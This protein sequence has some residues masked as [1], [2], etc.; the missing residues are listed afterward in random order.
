MH[1]RLALTKHAQRCPLRFVFW[2]R[3]DSFVHFRTLHD[4]GGAS[5]ARVLRGPASA[6]CPL[7]WSIH[8]F[9]VRSCQAHSQLSAPLSLA[10]CALQLVTSTLLASTTEKAHDDDDDDD[11]SLVLESNSGDFKHEVGTRIVPQPP[12][13]TRAAHHSAALI[14]LGRPGHV[15]S[16]GLVAC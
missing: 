3:S 16:L 2:V 14:I 7:L 9:V 12:R 4:K 15:H 8:T 10:L 11:G 1:T 5:R 13:G 6:W